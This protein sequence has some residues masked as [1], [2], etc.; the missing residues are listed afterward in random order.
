MGGSGE[1]TLRMDCPIL[2][3]DISANYLKASFSI[4][5][6]LDSFHGIPKRSPN[7]MEGDGPGIQT[8]NKCTDE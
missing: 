1:P 6:Y 3:V 7:S 2:V 4:M 8:Q 5:N